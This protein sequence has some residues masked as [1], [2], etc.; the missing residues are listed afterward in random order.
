MN[1]KT[2]SFPL[3]WPPALKARA[4]ERAAA[5]GL[6]LNG[7]VCVALDAYLSATVPPPAMP[8]P[9]ATVPPPAF[10]PVAPATPPAAPAAAPADRPA[11]ASPPAARPAPAAPAAQLNRQQRRAKKRR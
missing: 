6:S 8:P 7:F 9:P 11:P 5:V 4:Q 1:I 2:T 3:R 10:P